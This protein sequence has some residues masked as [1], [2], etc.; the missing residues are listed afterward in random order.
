MFIDDH[1]WEQAYLNGIHEAE[2][3]DYA[4]DTTYQQMLVVRGIELVEP[5]EITDRQEKLVAA[6]GKT[7]ASCPDD[8][9]FDFIT[10]DNE[11]RDYPMRWT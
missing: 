5:V 1:T 3:Q 2:Q 7:L 11:T 9:L 10:D 8:L 6:L 4:D